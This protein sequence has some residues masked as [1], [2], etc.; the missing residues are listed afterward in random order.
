MG[1][2]L[3]STFLNI[4]DGKYLHW[5]QGCNRRH[6]VT[7]ESPESASAHHQVLNGICAYTISGGYITY[8]AD[9]FHELRGQT[10]PLKV[11]ALT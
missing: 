8:T 9:C 6:W 2:L 11:L 5:C 3:G 10:V 4:G 1:Y 7:C